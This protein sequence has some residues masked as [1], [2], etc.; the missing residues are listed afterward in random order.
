VVIPGASHRFEEPGAWDMVLDL[1]RD[2]FS[3]GQVLL[4]EEY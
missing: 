2:W 1:T 4:A 3:F